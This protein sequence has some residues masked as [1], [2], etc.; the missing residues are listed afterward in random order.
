MDGF[1]VCL[2]RS[3]ACESVVNVIRV[4]TNAA[5]VIQELVP[6]DLRLN[7]HVKVAGMDLFWPFNG[8]FS[9]GQRN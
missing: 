2:E 4:F 8:Q 6:M 5:M 3:D 9:R 7:R 1:A